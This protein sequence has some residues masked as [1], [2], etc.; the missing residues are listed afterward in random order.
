MIL[1]KRR[2]CKICKEYIDDDKYIDHLIQHGK[3]AEK[4]LN[5]FNAEILKMADELQRTVR[6]MLNEVRELIDALEKLKEVGK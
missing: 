5:E 6:N 3:E 1:K 2:Y 4:E